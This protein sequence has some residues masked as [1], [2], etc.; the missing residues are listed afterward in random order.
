VL[1]RTADSDAA[2]VQISDR[3]NAALFKIYTLTGIA[4]VLGAFFSLVAAE[5]AAGMP[6]PPRNAAYDHKLEG[7][8]TVLDAA[9]YEGGAKFL[10][11]LYKHDL[12]A[13][14]AKMGRHGP[15]IME[16]ERQI[17][18]GQY[19]ADFELLGPQET[20]L[21][22]FPTL[23]ASGT[24]GAAEWHIKG[25]RRVSIEWQAIEKVAVCI[26]GAADFVLGPEEHQKEAKGWKSRQEVV[27]GKGRSEWARWTREVRE[28]MKDEDAKVQ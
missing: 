2:K 5:E 20:E 4:P 14:V 23:L 6:G 22:V 7:A 17:I 18:Y 15:K 1:E 26:A 28:T 21:V 25:A 11:M 3:F 24:R 19:L 12:P 8:P 16:M 13:I 10:D 9:N 27:V